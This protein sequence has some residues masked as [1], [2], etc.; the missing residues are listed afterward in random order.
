MRRARGAC[1]I[2]YTLFLVFPGNLEHCDRLDLDQ[3]IGAAEN[4][5]NAGGGGQRVQALLAEK[6][7]ALFVERGVI[8]VDIAQVARS[9]DDVLPGGAFRLQKTRNVLVRA[10]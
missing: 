6:V 5:L 8:P 4:R 2:A 10:P 3:Q 9:A 7:G 1:S